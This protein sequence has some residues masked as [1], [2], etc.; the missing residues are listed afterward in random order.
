MA[1][2]VD[3]SI[4]VSWILADENSPIARKALAVVAQQG[5]IVPGIFWY[6]FRNTLIVNERRGRLQLSESEQALAVIAAIDPQ[7]ADSHSETELLR[8]ARTHHM[9]VY[10]AAYVEL[11]FRQN[12]ELATLDEKMS[13]AAA[14]EGIPTVR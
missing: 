12:L 6:E 8:L 2:V 11:A 3:S 7:I 5:M 1:L 9:S 14:K 4:A 10:D 13:I